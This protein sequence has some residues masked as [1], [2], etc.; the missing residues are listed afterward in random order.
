MS[1]SFSISRRGAREKV[2]ANL[3]ADLALPKE[4]SQKQIE[5]LKLYLAAMIDSFPKDIN[6]ASVV[7]NGAINEHRIT[8]ETC[9]VQGENNPDL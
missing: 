2:K 3:A 6:A 5:A 4:S 8:L 9:V 1:N 7:A